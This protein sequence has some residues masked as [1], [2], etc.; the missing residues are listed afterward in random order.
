[1]PTKSK[2]VYIATESFVANV[3]G[4]D[5]VFTEGRSRVYEGDEILERCPEHFIRIEDG[6]E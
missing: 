3:H 6:E 1:M 5:K 2:Q 4:R